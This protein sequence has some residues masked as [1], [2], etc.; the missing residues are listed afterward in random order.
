M[1]AGFR[2]LAHT[3]DLGIESWGPDLAAALEQAVC[4]LGALLGGAGAGR[5]VEARPVRLAADDEDSLVVALL[6]EALFLLEAEGWLSVAAALGVDGDGRLA[7]D[8]LG[9]P[10]DA[11]RHAEGQAVK[12][13]TWHGL[14]VARAPGRVTVTVYLDL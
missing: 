6:Q 4:A 5:T 8:L 1:N 14:S 11:L 10:F 12:A 7:G 3:A 9:E 2:L 13:V